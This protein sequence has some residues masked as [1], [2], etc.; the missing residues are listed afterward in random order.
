[1]R[2]AR[3]LATVATVVM[4]ATAVPTAAV[5]VPP[6]SVVADG[7]AM[8]TAQRQVGFTPADGVI[9][10][11][12]V[13]REPRQIL[14]HVI[15]AIRNTPRGEKVRIAVWNFDDRPTADA[16]V[17]AF[18]R[19]VIVQLVVAGSVDSA[20]F[21]SVATVLNERPHDVSFAI[22]CRGAC[23]SGRKVMHSKIFLF[24]RSGDARHVSMFGSSNLTTPAGN[25]QWNDLVT[26]SSRALF[27]YFEQTFI[28]YALDTPV[29]DPYVRDDIGRYR[30]YL[31]PSGP[32]RNPV[33]DELGRIECAGALGMPGGRTR[34]RIAVAGWFDAYGEKIARRVKALWDAGC[35]VR[36]I[37]TLTGRGVNRALR[38]AK[39]RGPVPIRRLEEDRN[40]D[41]T[42]ERYLHM[43][44]IAIT[45]VFDGNPR[46]KVVVTGSPN[47]STSASNSDEVLVRIIKSGGLAA[48]YQRWIDH[49]YS[50]PSAHSRVRFR[51]SSR[52]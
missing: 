42:A 9:F 7:T 14:T 32:E 30:V 45:G 37:N 5:A 13:G 41:G 3:W 29:A 19:G 28:E 43:K 4:V 35:D 16:L 46:A 25:R 47:W 20:S 21:R 22:K 23:R 18:E 10:S 40:G 31:Y 50:S 49:L 44:A 51:E 12:P 8:R 26:V 2:P 33:L 6:G 38:S 27:E 15:K 1:M 39:G 48:T 52:D 36:I 34:I 11:N 24:T 17:K